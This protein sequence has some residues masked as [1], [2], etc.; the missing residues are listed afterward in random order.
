M[1]KY[2]KLLKKHI[3]KCTPTKKLSILIMAAMLIPFSGLDALGKTPKN[4]VLVTVKPLHSLVQAVMGD[5]GKARLLLTKKA[6]PHNYNLKPSDIK[7]LQKASMVFYIDK[8]FETFLNPALKNLPKN[9]DKIS[10]V[11]LSNHLPFKGSE[12]GVFEK[13]QENKKKYEKRHNEKV[14]HYANRSNRQKDGKRKS[15][16]DG[17]RH[18]NGGNLHIWLSPR[19]TLEAIRVIAKSLAKRYPENRDIYKKNAIALSKRV[20]QKVREIKAK[21]DS[22]ED[23]PFIVFHNAYGYFTNSFDLNSVAVISINS[24]I[25]PSANKILWIKDRIKSTGAVCA[26]KEP[27][28]SSKAVYS[29]I[30]GTDVKVGT[31]DPLGANIPAGSQMYFK[32]LDDLSDGFKSCLSRGK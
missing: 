3:L 25:S 17:L 4:A 5:T 20:K 14:N 10:I 26:F 2:I 18:G 32:L 6:T 21:L 19:K 7:L 24:T 23:V 1:T 31:L 15:H 22:V 30:K 27:Q 16:R 8:S 28:F 13:R 11:Y 9:V 12:Q 29:V